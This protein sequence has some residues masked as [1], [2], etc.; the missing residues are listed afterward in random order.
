MSRVLIV[1]DEIHLATGLRFNLEAEGHD[2]KIA[3]DG[4]IATELLLNQLEPFDVI[5]LDVM[6][7]GK[8]GFSVVSELRAS[9]NY[10]PVLC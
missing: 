2:V 8:D 5:I 10:T 6:L 3:G 1:E 4:E 7:P 9:K